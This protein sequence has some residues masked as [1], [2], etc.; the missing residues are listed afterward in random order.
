ML[1]FHQGADGFSV[2]VD[3]DRIVAAG[4]KLAP[5]DGARVRAWPGELRPGAL[6]TGALPDAPSARERVYAA[7]R[8]G[9]TGVVLDADADRQDPELRAAATRVGMGSAAGRLA[10][11]ERADFAV[12]DDFDDACIATVVAGRIVHRRR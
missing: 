10:A 9:A 11:G 6:W 4:R 3:R 7:L 8:A 1:T 5:P 12:F 2:L